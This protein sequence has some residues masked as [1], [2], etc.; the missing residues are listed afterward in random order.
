MN[1]VQDLVP[2]CAF[3]NKFSNRGKCIRNGVCIG[4]HKDNTIRKQLQYIGCTKCSGNK[5]TIWRCSACYSS[6]QSVIR[7]TSNMV[8]IPLLNLFVKMDFD[9]LNN[10]QV[11]KYST[12]YSEYFL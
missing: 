5:S 6:F 12:D 4:S 8:P 10:Q 9:N 3:T 1:I 7:T 11:I 2:T